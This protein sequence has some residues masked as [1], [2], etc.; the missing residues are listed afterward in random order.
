MIS[1]LRPRRTGSRVK[2]A[3]RS[4]GITAGSPTKPPSHTPSPGTRWRI[5]NLITTEF[6]RWDSASNGVNGGE[7]RGGA[8]EPDVQGRSE[9]SHFSTP[10]VSVSAADEFDPAAR[11]PR[12]YVPEQKV[13]ESKSRR[14]P[15]AP[16][17]YCSV[18][19]ETSEP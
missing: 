7:T 10:N 17:A 12:A 8:N 15:I 2:A 6:R 5:L 11:A 14:S 4:A 13:L 1:R 16:H 3:R 9:R 18:D 19:Q